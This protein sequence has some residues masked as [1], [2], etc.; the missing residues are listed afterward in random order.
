MTLA[1][2]LANSDQ[3]IQVSDRRLTWNGEL[4]DEASNKAGHILCND[5]SILYCFTGLACIGEHQTIKWLQDALYQIAQKGIHDYYSLTDH[6]S[7]IA[8]K[9]FKESHTIQKLPLEGRALSVL[10]TG[11]TPDGFIISTLVSNFEYFEG[12][13]CTKTHANVQGDF[14]IFRIKSCYPRSENENPTYIKAIGQHK[15]IDTPIKLELQNMLQDRLPAEVIRQKAI[16]LIQKMSNDGKTGGTVG[17]RINT[18]RLQWNDPISPI[19]GYASDIVEN[20]MPNIDRSDLRSGKPL[21]QISGVQ[22]SASEPFVFPNVH[23]NAPCPC[24]SGKKYRHC[25]RPPR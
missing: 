22:L 14:S 6:F 20:V 2:V 11:Y 23:R 1:I 4:R 15:F 19:S 24:G 16:S 9:H 5:A 10:F 17:K 7:R 3:I 18:A 12:T 21:F 25:H 8:T 13:D